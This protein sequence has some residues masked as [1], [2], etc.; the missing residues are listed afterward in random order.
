MSE[1]IAGRL[2]DILLSPEDEPLAIAVGALLDTLPEALGPVDGKPAC[3]VFLGNRLPICE[4]EERARIVRSQGIQML[5]DRVEPPAPVKLMRKVDASERL[6]GGGCTERVRDR[7]TLAL[8]LLV[9]A[10]AEV[11]CTALGLGV[12]LLQLAS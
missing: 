3:S 4:R 5:R 9:C 2:K 7:P 10:I 8:L 11:D 12:H 1:R 6:T